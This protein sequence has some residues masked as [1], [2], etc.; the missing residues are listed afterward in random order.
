[1]RGILT[2]L[3]NYLSE[4]AVGKGRHEAYKYDEKDR[5]KEKRV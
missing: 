1:M 5:R 2:I 3:H 4:A